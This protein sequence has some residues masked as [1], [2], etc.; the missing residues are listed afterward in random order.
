MRRLLQFLLTGCM[1]AAA[2]HA[3]AQ[4]P[5]PAE[6][7]LRP[8]VLSP[9]ALQGAV[10]ASAR[11]GKRLV[12]VGDRGI[13][14]L[15]DDQGRSFR[16]AA[17][18]PVD[19]MLTSVS[20][21]DDR[22]GWAVGH[23]GLVLA[24]QDGGE[25]WAVQ[26]QDLQADRPLFAVH[27]FDAQHGVAVGLWSL[28]L[29]TD[30]GGAHWRSVSLPAPPGATKADLNLFSLFADTQGR[31]FA[32]GERGMVLTSTDRGTTWAYAATGYKGSLWTG[33]ALSGGVLLVG[34]LRGSLYRSAD[35]GRS[36]ERVPVDARSSIT[37]IVA[38]GDRVLAVGLDGLML[39]S[40]DAGRSF[41]AEWLPGRAALTSLSLVVGR[42]P[43]LF[44]RQ[45][46][47]AATSATAATEAAQVR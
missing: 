22:H 1:A 23:G 35:G 26:R 24:T 43:V 9:H 8:A 10:L 33:A 6:P 12:A 3:P 41:A 45:G 19:L 40:D 37:Q 38:E 30:D 11:A 34:G 36:W 15:S 44:S 47:V 2:C 4:P 18:V 25:H 21:A 29:V 27:F 7:L 28:V 39:R 46:P 5:L 17:A 14:L 31:V 16:Q 32:A 13:V 20:F 42:R